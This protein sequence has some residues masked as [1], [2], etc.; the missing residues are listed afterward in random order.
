MSSPSRV[1][2]ICILGVWVL[3][4]TIAGAASVRYEGIYRY[5]APSS[6]GT[7]YLRFYADGTALSVLSTGSPR[8]VVRWFHRGPKAPE[9]GHYTVRGDRIHF[10]TFG[11]ESGTDCSGSIQH[12]SLVLQ[13]HGS[14]ARYRFHFLPMRLAQ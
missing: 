1:L 7:M 3:A 4:H 10:T 9:S 13:C 11:F 5:R 2:R 14:R 8:Q 6:D 12:A